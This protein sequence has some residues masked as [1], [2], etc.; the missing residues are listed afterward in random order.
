MDSTISWYQWL[1]GTSYD[2]RHFLWP[3]KSSHMTLKKIWD[4]LPVVEKISPPP[5]LLWICDCPEGC[6]WLGYVNKRNPTQND[7]ICSVL[8]RRP[9]TGILPP[10]FLVNVV[11]GTESSC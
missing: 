1:Q 4:A 2:F 9:Y 10:I 3:P 6:S 5:P 11:K 8:M 7:S